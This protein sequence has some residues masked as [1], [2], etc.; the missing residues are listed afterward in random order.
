ML[1]RRLALFRSLGQIHISSKGGPQALIVLKDW[2]DG[3]LE[4][5]ILP[6]TFF[7]R[8]A[9]LTRTTAQTEDQLKHSQKRHRHIANMGS[10]DTPPPHVPAFLIPLSTA[11]LGAGVLLWDI[12][13]VLMTLRGIRTRSSSMPLL[14]LA[15]NISWEILYG[16][17]IAD[18][19][20][21]KIGFGFWLVLDLG[22]IYC[23]V[24][25]APLDWRG[26]PRI[27]EHMGLILTLM[28]AVGLWGHWAFASWWLEVPHRNGDKTGKW[29]RGQEG[30][31]VTEAAFWAAAVPQLMINA[32]SIA[33]L[34]SRGHSG[35]TSY[36]IW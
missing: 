24:A 35:G 27:G 16:F 10:N 8:H 36:A 1:Q 20:L 17:Y 22:L 6:L 26:S 25:Y 2:D 3:I 28:T 29:W 23:T 32:G 34:L 7:Y 31:D 4:K 19:L 9:K 5:V 14:A 11:V 33:M 13:Y 12:T 21:D 15:T 30:Y 18:P